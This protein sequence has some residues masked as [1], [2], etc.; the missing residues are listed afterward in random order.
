MSY[1]ELLFFVTFSI[2]S[3]F[4]LFSYHLNK[5]Y[6]FLLLYYPNY[7]YG[8][9]IKLFYEIIKLC[10]AYFYL[11]IIKQEALLIFEI[12]RVFSLST[13]SFIK[14]IIWTTKGLNPQPE[15]QVLVQLIS[16]EARGSI[17]SISVS[18]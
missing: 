3:C 16:V 6:I 11:Q 10:Y 1:V 8:V 7:F 5:L 17:L 18:K 15:S 2:I 12:L 14:Y 9:T 4:V 13:F